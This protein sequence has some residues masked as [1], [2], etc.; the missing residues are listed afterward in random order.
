MRIVFFGTDEVAIPSMEE[1]L[2]RGFEILAVVTSPDA[3]SGRGRKL[4]APATKR[5]AEAHGI[6]VLQPEKLRKN[7]EIRERLRSYSADLFVVLS[8]GKIIP[9]SIFNIPPRGSINLHFSLLP[10]L[11]GAAPI[12]WAILRGIRDTGATVF[13]LDKGLDTGPVLAQMRFKIEDR[14]NY[15]EAMER[16]SRITAP[17]FVETAVRWIDGR[18]K[19]IP[20][21][22][23]P[24]FAPRVE[25]SMASLSFDE[26][27]EVLWRKIRA[28]NPDLKPW[29]PF[30]G[31][32]LIVHKAHYREG[33]E[34]PGKVLGKDGIALLVGTSRGILEL[35]RVQLPGKKPVDGASF[36]NGARLK[37]GDYLL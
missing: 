18:I 33:S 35:H 15:G 8:Y 5:F 10:A 13:L 14:E 30:R 12:R 25:K 34:V 3:P 1:F 23:E 24:T 17:F 2:R 9:P 19:P 7:P 29:F 26:P 4:K 6:E 37:P 28:F 36:A 31:E 32:R 22:G 27:A 21:K 16:I 20:Q 11:R